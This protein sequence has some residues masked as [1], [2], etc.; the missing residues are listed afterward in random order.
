[1]TLSVDPLP[2]A[3]ATARNREPILAGLARVLAGSR[4]VLEIAS[5]TGE[6][7]EFFAR[8][9]PV[10]AWLPSDAD[11]E[12][13]AGISRRVEQ[14]GLQNLKPPVELDV[15]EAHWPVGQADAVFCAN[16]I[17]IAPWEAAKGLMS[18]AAR[19][20]PPGGPLCVYG[21]FISD[22][23]PTAPS[24]TAFDAWLR[25]RNPV[26][27]IRRLE[28]VRELAASHRLDLVEIIEM[29]ANNLML[30]FAAGGDGT[31]PD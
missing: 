21:P 13:V 24:N 26:W 5:G 30:V 17:H 22:D 11:S 27:G 7:A 1:M 20:L 8:S 14:A 10:L 23:R 16:M 29:P 25:A 18:G 15:R 6:H 3:P 19:I 9:L 4:T 31:K 28:T 2:H 12:N